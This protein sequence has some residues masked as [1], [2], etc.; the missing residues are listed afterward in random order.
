MMTLITMDA[1]E[2]KDATSAADHTKPRSV[3]CNPLRGFI[4]STS[5]HRN[6]TQKRD[7]RGTP[8]VAVQA[9]LDLLD[10]LVDQ[11]AVAL[12]ALT[13]VRDSLIDPAAS[14]RKAA[15]SA[16]N[17]RSVATPHAHWF[18]ASGREC[19]MSAIHT[20]KQSNEWRRA[21]SPPTPSC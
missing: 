15:R 5:Q 14:S 12:A 4:I 3:V 10:T 20:K 13:W 16:A 11:A 6:Q 1:S 9:P 8:M 19:L 2:L 21:I 7:H 18:L 17:Q